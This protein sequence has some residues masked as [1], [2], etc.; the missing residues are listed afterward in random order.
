MSSSTA[1]LRSPAITELQ[2]VDV[3]GLADHDRDALIVTAI[4]VDEHWVI[5][6][7]Y[8]DDIWRL[9]GFS[10]NVSDNLRR[11]DFSRVPDPFRA[12]MK[13]VL[14]RYLRRGLEG[15][16]RPKSGTV[17]NF[18]ENTLPFLRYLYTLKLSHFG[19][20]TPLVC[21]NYAAECRSQLQTRRSRGQPLSREALSR[22]FGTIEALYELS[23]YTHDPIPLHPWPDTSASAMAG[24][25]STRK[26][27]GKTPLMPDEAFCTLFK[28]AEEQIQCGKALL[29][30]R[31]A[32]AAVAIARRMQDRRTVIEAKN[33]CLST[34]GWKGGLGAFN[35]A[36]LDLRA[37]CY[38]VLASTSGCR[39]HEL[40]NLQL[41][42]HH[43]TEDDEGTIYHWMRSKSDKTDTGIHDW[44][45]PEAAV[46]ALRLIERWAEPYQALIAAEIVERRRIDPRDPEIAKA[47]KHQH[48]LFIGMT[49]TKGNQVRTLSGGTWNRVLKAFAHSN[50]VNW[51]LASHQFRRKFANYAAHSQFG[52]LRYLREHYAHWSMDMTLDYAMDKGWGLHLD[53]ELFSDIRAEHED[54][55][56][57][58]VETW[59]GD[60]LLAG[61]YGR[62]IKRWQ[63]DPANLAIFK[64]HAV[65]LTSIAESTAI[66]SNGH[67]WCTASDDRCIGNTLERTRCADCNNAVIGRTHV[68][69]Y[70]RLYDN[71]KGLQYSR[72]IG[73]GGRQR[74]LRD[75]ERCRNVLVQLGYNP[76]ANVV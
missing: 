52:D 22:R 27:G 49:A 44:M 11:I 40:A 57:G 73:D 53:L 26:Q 61:G 74:V 38:I 66:R 36:I 46:R 5:L 20:V 43:R 6:S 21:T 13:A 70:Q 2:Q 12:L 15:Q 14:Y 54:I 35:Q 55:K 31:D 41:G 67:S 56:L 24:Y 51:N 17:R 62:S 18:F 9:D 68:G 42:A 32:L 76:E 7:Q 45:I 29:D 37:A 33:H 75:L 30:L 39:N 71:L 48:A 8:G 3:R 65:M 19:A 63:R 64:S 25:W 1:A 16:K 58:V 72:D 10:N 60:E 28:S 34:L 50:G 59:L 69:I 4:Q 47:Q 23:Q